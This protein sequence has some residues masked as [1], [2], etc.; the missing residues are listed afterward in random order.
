MSRDHNQIKEQK[1]N[2]NGVVGQDHQEFNSL[3][4]INEAHYS[5]EFIVTQPVGDEIQEGLLS[6]PRLINDVEKLARTIDYQNL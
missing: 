2:D 6:E 1:T 5:N 4:M 3:E